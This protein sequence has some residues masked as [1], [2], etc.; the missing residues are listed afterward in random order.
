MGS[1]RLPGKVLAEI[2]GMT[3]LGLQISRLQRGGFDTVVATSDTPADDE[4]AGLAASLG[5]SVVRGPESDVLERYRLTAERFEDADPIV[6]LTADCPLTDPAIVH[7]A[8][9]AHLRWNGDH[10]SNVLARTFP[11][12]FDVEVIRRAALLTAASEAIASDEREHVTPF[13]LRDPERFD[14]TSFCSG[15]QAGLLRMTLD[16]ENDLA[17]LR[18]ACERVS[19]PISAVWH[20]FITPSPLPEGVSAWPRCIEG[21]I[22][23]RHFDV[24]CDGSSIGE[25]E[26]SVNAGRG[27]M[28]LDVPDGAVAIEARAWV[29][30]WLLLDTQVVSVV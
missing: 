27:R 7:Q 21:R 24:L 10:T 3:A 14:L 9:T 17:A 22:R 20:A 25:V 4:V 1:T 15:T 5:V 23:S 28:R 30:R 16:T 11:D 26:V 29:M 12:G 19:D 8:I 2:A 6:R 18:A 13:L